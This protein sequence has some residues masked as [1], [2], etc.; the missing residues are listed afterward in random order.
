M[1]RQVHHAHQDLGH[2]LRAL[3]HDLGANLMLL[4]GSFAQLKQSLVYPAADVAPGPEGSLRTLGARIAHVDACLTQ[5]QRLLEDLA[6]L[7]RTGSIEM[8]SQQVELSAVIDE[9]LFEQSE[10]FSQRNIE[11]TVDRPLPICR[12]N[13]GRLKQVLTN[14]IRNAALH[15]CDQRQPQIVIAARE[16]D[17]NGHGALTTLTIHDNGPALDR[18]LR[19]EIFL[20]GRG[21]AKRGVPSSGMGL[22]VV[23]E[24]VAHYG[25]STFLDPNCEAG[26]RFVVQLPAADEPKHERP[27]LHQA[28]WDSEHRHAAAP[29]HRVRPCR[30]SGLKS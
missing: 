22:A 15:G 13:R 11:V 6:Q 27:A 21:F 18:R 17:G 9:V 2:S 5:S 14:L 7:A 25:G 8:E 24:I 1:A 23:R 3:S 26:N 16:A 30:P 28:I 12:I 4:Q 19:E 20:P 10:L 29:A